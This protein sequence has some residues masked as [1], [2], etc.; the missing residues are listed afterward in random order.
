METGRILK[1]ISLLKQ[2]TVSM[3]PPASELIKQEC[4]SDPFNVLIGC[5]LSFRTKDTVSFPAACR[6][7]HCAKT[8]QK[9]RLLD[10]NVIEQLIY[11][12]GFYRQK[13]RQLRALCDRLITDFD[14]IVP[15]TIDELLTLEGVG[16]KTAN[17]VLAE[18]FGIPA[19]CVDTHVHRIANRLGLVNTKTPQETEFALKAVAPPETWIDLSRLLVMWGQNICVPISPLCSKCILFPVCLRVGVKKSR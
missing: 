8:P 19:L 5:L 14:G 15:N 12:V 4:G 9:L 13:A 1:I 3:R 16:R 11:P 2:G 6:L 7:L 17:L 10:Q 18:G